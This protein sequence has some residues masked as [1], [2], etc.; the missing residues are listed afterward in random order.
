MGSWLTLQRIVG[1]T[2]PIKF[3]K[4]NDMIILEQIPEIDD[5]VRQAHIRIE[6]PDDINLEQL[7]NEFAG[8]CMALSYNPESVKEELGEYRYE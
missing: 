6:L 5:E 8:F 2:N 3:R 7:V 1:V 4:E